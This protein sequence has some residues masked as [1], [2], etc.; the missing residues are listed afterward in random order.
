MSSYS[1]FVL[2]MCLPFA[3][4]LSFGCG[5]SGGDSGAGGGDGAGNGAS[6]GAG[7]SIDPTGCD[8]TTVALSSGQG[9]TPSVLWTGSAF[10]AAFIENGVVRVAVVDP[11][12]D[13]VGEAQASDSGGSALPSLYALPNDVVAV[14]WAEGGNILARHAD[15]AASMLTGPMVV[16]QTSSPEPRPSAA[17]L[18]NGRLAMAWMEQPSSTLATVDGSEVI[19]TTTLGGW[20]PALATT[21]GGAVVAWSNGGE[22]GPVAFAFT[23]QTGSAAT[24]PGSSA[25]IKAVEPFDGGYAVAWEDVGGSEPQVVMATFGDNGAYR[26]DAQISPSSG[27]A[28]WPAMAYTGSQIALAYY[29]FRDGPPS[30]YLTFVDP[31]TLAS[32]DELL[33]AD[34]AKYPSVAV[35]GAT[36][37]VAYAVQ[38]GPAELLLLTCDE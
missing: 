12:G 15:T 31:D 33:V 7:G 20:F 4:W 24:V 21:G 26:D 37:A 11:S 1:K 28:N 19:D 13:I 38:E 2:T 25:L 18:G 29:Q 30:V 10:H 3:A 27:S 14:V 6:S 34:D 35:G 32:S 5:D 17:S 36:I 23:D 9:F 8:R 16:S 22:Q